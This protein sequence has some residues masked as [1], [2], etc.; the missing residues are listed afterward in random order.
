MGDHGDLGGTAEVEVM[1]SGQRGERETLEK[2][3]VG[4]TDGLDVGLE[5][6]SW[7]FDLGSKIDD[8]K[9]CLINGD[10][11]RKSSLGSHVFVLSCRCG[12][13]GGWI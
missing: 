2:S 7:S 11:F 6:Y 13:L 9:Y 1:I 10:T 8:W 12:Q 3:L 5:H 4:F